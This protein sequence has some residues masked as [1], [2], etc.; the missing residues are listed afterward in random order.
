MRGRRAGSMLDPRE[1]VLRWLIKDFEGHQGAAGDSD[2]AREDYGCAGSV[3]LVRK[4]LALL[5]PREERAA[6]KTGY[7]A[8]RC[9][10]SIGPRCRRGR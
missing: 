3:D 2:S 7:R 4:R 8:G 6:Q 1:P 5:R 10:R 9:C